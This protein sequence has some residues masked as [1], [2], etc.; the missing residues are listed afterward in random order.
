VRSSL[1]S[2]RAWHARTRT[3]IDCWNCALSPKLWCSTEMA[4]TST[5][6]DA[7]IREPDDRLG[8]IT[9]TDPTHPLY[10]RSFDLVSSGASHRPSGYVL[11]RYHDDILLRVRAA[12]TD[13]HSVRLSVPSSKLSLDSIRDLLRLS[14]RTTQGGWANQQVND[15]LEHGSESNLASS[16]G[17]LGGEP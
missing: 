15:S 8:Q 16:H 9:V 1:W 13:L 10:G 5:Q 17:S 3:G 4:A 11:V 6:L 14:G 7:P 12:A 2:L